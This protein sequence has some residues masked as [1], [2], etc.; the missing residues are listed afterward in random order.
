MPKHF[1]QRNVSRALH[2]GSAHFPPSLVIRPTLTV[3]CFKGQDFEEYVS[4]KLW[5]GLPGDVGLLDGIMHTDASTTGD[6]HLVEAL[7]RLSMG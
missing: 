1:E 3:R 2:K 5:E 4:E 7:T 6:R